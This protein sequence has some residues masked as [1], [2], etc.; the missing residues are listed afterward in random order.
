M[1]KRETTV[2]T[3]ERGACRVLRL[4]RSGAPGGWS[5]ALRRRYAAPQVPP[6]A[7]ERKEGAGEATRADPVR[8]AFDQAVAAA[9]GRAV[10]GLPASRLLVKILRMPA[11]VREDLDDAIALQMA[12]VAPFTGSDMT[13]SGEVVAETGEELTVFAAVLP[14]A[15]VEH[16]DGWLRDSHLRVERVDALLLGWW[17]AAGA[18]IGAN[19]ATPQ[20]RVFLACAADEWDLLVADGTR[21]ILVRG[22]GAVADPQALI[23]ELTLSLLNA[24]VESGPL[25]LSEVVL[26][27]PD[28]V[29]AS[30][31]DAVRLALAVPIRHSPP[32]QADADL[33]GLALRDIG[34]PS[35]RLN[36]LPDLWRARN[37]AGDAGKRF[38][39]WAVALAALW[40]VV[41]GALFGGPIWMR[42]R[43][44]AVER[45]QALNGADFQAVQNIRARAELI[46]SYTDRSDS[47]LEVMRVA[48][49]VMPDGVELRT[50]VYKR[51]E[52]VKLSGEAADPTLVY[53][54]KDA[55]E[56][57]G[58][59]GV[60]AVAG[61]SLVRDAAKPGRHRFEINAT[62]K[63]VEGIE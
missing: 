56:H 3:V 33:L 38:L 14:H 34:E 40:L 51:T 54:F 28:P 6:E 7:A 29:D 59:F 41:A 27:T 30:L 48:A 61:V 46:E 10:L 58:P 43:V 35:A 31:A 55:I 62:F 2:L 49:E 37:A 18:A 8:I 11:A 50:V 57:N 16:L 24:E 19:D 5:A 20:R 45:E 15:A 17:R 44:A 26:C 22:L 39:R 60:C 63:K 4:V 32:M 13:V 9:S 42:Q 21:P 53:R 1:A 36:L 47:V 25:S 23:L 52:S 12:K